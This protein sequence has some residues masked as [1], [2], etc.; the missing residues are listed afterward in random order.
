MKVVITVQIEARDSETV[1]DLIQI[2]E[3]TASYMADNV[4]VTS[5]L[6]A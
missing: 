5:E 2:I 1:D 6:S 4:M 3:T